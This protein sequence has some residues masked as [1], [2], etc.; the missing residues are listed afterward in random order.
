MY[1]PTATHPWHDYFF[2]PICEP[3]IMRVFFVCHLLH[4]GSRNLDFFPSF[5]CKFSMG[6]KNS[7]FEPRSDISYFYDLLYFTCNTEPV[8]N[9]YFPKFCKLAATGTALFSLKGKF[10]LMCC[11][12][13]C[14]LSYEPACPRRDSP[15][16]QVD[17]CQSWT[18][19]EHAKMWLKFVIAVK[20]GHSSRV[21]EGEAPTELE[22][23]AMV[24]T[25]H[26]PL[27]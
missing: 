13:G 7:L 23:S 6:L 9:V 11:M 1:M 25:C 10:T 2:V 15:W 14:Y 22:I 3:V 12:F 18:M 19:S 20:L 21:L 5:L 24:C 4:G 16:G 27:S 26:S 17:S 8:K